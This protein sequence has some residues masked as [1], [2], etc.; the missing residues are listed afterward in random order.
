MNVNSKSV[1]AA[2][3]AASLAAPAFGMATSAFAHSELVSSVPAAGESVTGSVAELRLFFSEP[4]EAAFNKVTVVGA[5]KQPLNA[6][7][8][9]VDPADG[10][11]VVVG[12]DKPLAQGTFSVDWSVVSTDG[13]KSSGSYAFDVK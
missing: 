1:R 4:V 3:V 12:L 7:K 8:P 13:H 11:V 10:K 9:V 6:D 5:D 2:L